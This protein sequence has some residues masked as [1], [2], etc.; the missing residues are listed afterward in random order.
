MLTQNHSRIPGPGD[1]ATPEDDRCDRL[2][3]AREIEEIAEL[4]RSIL[5]HLFA[6]DRARIANDNPPELIAA[7]KLVH[8]D[9]A[10]AALSS[11]FQTIRST[12]SSL[13]L[14]ADG[15]RSW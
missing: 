2:S 3:D 13:E 1:M 6:D 5:P 8:D 15:L 14:T 10:V 12:I 7:R 9:D 11:A 4:L